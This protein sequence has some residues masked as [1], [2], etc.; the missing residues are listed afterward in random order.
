MMRI[1]FRVTWTLRY[2]L[3]SCEHPPASMT[4]DV[5]PISALSLTRCDPL[6][7]DRSNLPR[8]RAIVGYGESIARMPTIAHFE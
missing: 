3:N 8:T 4:A 5:G 2:I 7:I 6:A 1:E